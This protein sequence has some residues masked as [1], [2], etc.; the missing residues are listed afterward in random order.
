MEL[1]GIDSF[2]AEKIKES[3]L[4]FMVWSHGVAVV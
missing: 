2:I 1:L 4:L 3:S